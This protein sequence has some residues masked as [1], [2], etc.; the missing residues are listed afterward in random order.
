[1]TKITLTNTRKNKKKKKKRQEN[2][3]KNIMR[4]IGRYKN[5]PTIFF[6]LCQGK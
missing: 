6:S 5:I 1:M 4:E 3:Y 2:M